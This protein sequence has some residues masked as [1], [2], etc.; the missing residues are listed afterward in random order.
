METF[1]FVRD[2]LREWGLSELI[3][4]FEDEGIDKESFLSLEESDIK[5]VIPKV[6]PRAKF[7]K[8]LKELLQAQQ[9]QIQPSCHPV[10][11]HPLNRSGLKEELGPSTSNF[12]TLPVT[13]EGKRKLDYET[14]L[15]KKKPRTS[16]Q[17]C[18]SVLGTSSEVNILANMKEIMKRVHDKLDEQGDTKLNA[19]LKDKLN[20]LETGKKQLVGVFGK[21]GAGKSSLINAIIGK[22]DLLPSG[23]VMACTSVM[24]KVEANMSNSKYMAEIE[25]ITKKEWKDELCSISDVIKENDDDDHFEKRSALYGT[26]N[27]KSPEELMGYKYF[28]E[29]PEFLKC[30]KKILTCESSSELSEKL[31]KYTRSDKEE[32]GRQYW[33]LVKC[34]TIKVPNVTDLLEHVTLVDL[35]GS[36]DS[37]KSRDEMWKEF[38][39]CCSTVWIVTDTNR[40]ASEKEP[41]EILNNTISLMGNGGECQ[42][43]S[44]ICTKSDAIEDSD[45]I[46]K[47]E[48]RAYILNRNEQAKK[49]VREKFNRQHKIKKHFIGDSDLLQVFTVSSREFQKEK[50]KFLQK[51]ETEIPDLQKCLQTLN[52]RQSKTSN[53][54]SG[55]YGILSLIQGANRSKMACHKPEV[56]AVLEQRI[57]DELDKVR[58]S[59]EEAY[60]VFENCLSEGVKKSQESCENNMKFILAP[61]GKQDRGFYAT[62]KFLVENDGIQKPKNKKKS[63]ININEKLTSCMRD[64]IDEEFKK[65]FPNEGRCG[66]FKGVINKFTL[67][68]D[69]LVDKYKDVSL[70]LIFLKTE[71]EKLKTNLNDYIREKKKQ[72]YGS[73]TYSIKDS[74]Q[75]CYEEAATHRGKDT[76]KNMR[77]TIEKH[78]KG[79]KNIMFNKAKDEMLSQMKRLMKRILKTLEQNMKRSI[80]LSLKTDDNSIPDVTEEYQRGKKWYDKLLGNP[81]KETPMTCGEPLKPKAAS[82]FQPM[83]HAQSHVSGV[84]VLIPHILH[85]TDDHKPSYRLDCPGAGLFQCASTGLV[86]EMEKKGEVLYRTVDWDNLPSTLTPAG[87]LFSIQCPCVRQLHLPHCEI[88][89]D[90]PDKLS[91]AHVIDGKMEEVQPNHMNA[92]HVV[93][94][95][96]NLS[97]YGLFRKSFSH[98]PVQGQVLL[99]HQKAE[100]RPH[101]CT[102]NVLLLPRN[103]PICEVESHQM[104]CTFIPTR[105]NCTLSPRGRY[106]L[107]CE[108]VARAEIQPKSGMFDCDYGQN[109]QSTFRVFLDSGAETV[110]LI[111]MDRGN[112]DQ[113]VWECLVPL[114]AAAAEFVKKQR[115][116]LIQ[117]VMMVLP[118]ADELLGKEVIREEMYTRISKET[119]NQMQMRQLLKAVCAAGSAAMSEFYSALRNHEP[120]LVADLAKC[121]YK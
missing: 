10:T 86:F 18:G 53:Y 116:A 55:G 56:C 3:Q 65:T 17:H 47:D 111:L 102:L 32:T 41:W 106:G 42:R 40:A 104:G 4:T 87:P 20:D 12:S 97:E 93:V 70:Q 29:I 69:S 28:F 44:F 35:P 78:L 101:S 107:G 37:N 73:L 1:D 68:T 98:L 90:D 34:V 82:D 52:D 120:Y 36:G 119:T 48:G 114:A 19:F 5:D 76:L 84:T 67:D 46:S 63:E 85:E 81:N 121:F 13:D 23:D 83:T 2:K 31:A 24:I 115:N 16:E 96:T 60:K 108:L 45:E 92:T 8:R 113:R 49:Q 99:F 88:L 91:V 117:R 39:G 80:E 9:I 50:E 51:D 118:I 75:P 110:R 57:K 14:E 26:D 109:Y 33:P 94:D 59:M 27:R 22:K 112:N 21:T 30:R 74:M 71:E 64:H 95:V 62:L 25:F 79:S 7:K 103:V 11:P 72:I 100:N 77:D 105:S 6:G 43:I 89:S 58:Q 38:V 66:P 15:S 61:K 54:V